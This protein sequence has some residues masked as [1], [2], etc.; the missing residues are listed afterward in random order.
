LGADIL[1]GGREKGKRKAE[2]EVTVEREI[3]LSKVNL[4]F[5]VCFSPPPTPTVKYLWEIREKNLGISLFLLKFYGR[6]ESKR[7][8]RL[9]RV[10]FQGDPTP[11]RVS[12]VLPPTTSFLP[13]LVL[14]FPRTSS[15]PPLSNPSELSRKRTVF[16]LR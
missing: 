10:S 15:K 12:S 2:E 11:T 6:S 1:S 3:D 16:S 8:E 7:Q 4:S 5:G 9:L 13:L 14:H